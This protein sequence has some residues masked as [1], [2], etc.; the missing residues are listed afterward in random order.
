MK[1]FLHQLALMVVALVIVLAIGCRPRS[2]TDPT[3][4]ESASK[5]P[6]AADVMK[7]IDKGDYAGA[8]EALKKVKE[9]V[10]TEDQNVQF[11]ILASEARTKMNVAATTNAQAAE[12]VAVLRAMTTGGR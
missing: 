4:V 6:G 11:M 12:V 8:M 3:V 10:S 7:A 9:T 2:A 1:K 5:L